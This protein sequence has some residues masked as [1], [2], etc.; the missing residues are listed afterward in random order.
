MVERIPR[1][2]HEITRDGVL[3]PHPGRRLNV[4]VP[5]AP[6]E[7]AATTLADCGPEDLASP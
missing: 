7:P 1:G 6:N 2:I 3:I 4:V 5:Y